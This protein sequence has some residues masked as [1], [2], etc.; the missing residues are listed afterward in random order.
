MKNVSRK[1]ERV[2][3][4]AQEVGCKAYVGLDVHKKSIN[5]AVWTDSRIV[6]T[7]VMPAENHK[8]VDCLCQLKDHLGEVVYEAGP[9]GFSLARACEQVGLPIKVVAPSK[10]P[11]PAGRESKSD[12]LDCRM[13]AKY[14]AKGLLEGI[15]VPTE[16][17]EADRQVTRVREQLA[18]KLRLTKQHIKSFLLQHGLKE[19]HGLKHWSL[20][21][22]EELRELEM[23]KE[24]RT[25]LEIYMDELEHA[26]RQ[27]KVV[28]ERM[29]ELSKE[30]RHRRKVEL[31]D[32]HLGVGPVTAMAFVTEIF[33][34]ERFKNGRQVSKQIG[35]APMVRQSGESRKE[36]KILRTGRG[37]LRRLLTQAAWSWINH[38][39]YAHETYLRLVGNTGS[40]LKAN[41]AMARRL[42]QN[43]WRMLA[44]GEVPL[45]VAT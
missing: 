10:T 7:W 5:A 22:I 21:A 45:H 41:V 17:E 40:K 29:K 11:R 23:R 27:L 28:E 14:S 12:R 38:D 1:L 26:K 36:G 35:L 34:P 39:P 43:L 4:I 32:M 31:L 30:E 44:Y 16:E 3:K 20:E 33:R 18:K 9:T 19:P 2:K 15:A 37:E 25:C 24:L 42:G 8:V 6:V 13:L